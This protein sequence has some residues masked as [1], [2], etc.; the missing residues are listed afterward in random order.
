[1]QC[2]GGSLPITSKDLFVAS[3]DVDANKNAL[4]N[5]VYATEHI[6]HL[7]KVPGVRAVTRMQSEPFA[8]SLG[9]AEQQVAHEGPQSSALYEIGRVPL[10]CGSCGIGT[11]TDR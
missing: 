3:M 10:A 2:I 5:E 7:L 11:C 6:P 8:V 4:F 9:G 1:M